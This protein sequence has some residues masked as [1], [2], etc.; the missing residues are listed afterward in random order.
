MIQ[1]SSGIHFFPNEAETHGC[2]KLMELALAGNKI[3]A[4]KLLEGSFAE[5]SGKLIRE[6]MAWDKSIS[7]AA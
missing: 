4:E 2:R 3:E 6:M 1:S 5:K 7:S